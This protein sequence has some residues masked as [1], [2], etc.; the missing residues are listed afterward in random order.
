MPWRLVWLLVS[1]ALAFAPGMVDAT[2]ALSPPA[3]DA[4]ALAPEAADPDPLGAPRLD[5]IGADAI[6]R[7]VVAALAQDR[8]GFVWVATGDGLTRFDGHR[9]RPLER[10]GDDP[11]ARNLGWIRALLGGRDGRLWIGTETDGLASYDPATDRV[12]DHGG[13]AG[14]RPWPTIRAL[15]EDADGAIWAGSV[16][17]G[18]LR[19]DRARGRF[20][21][22][23]ADGKAG[24]LPDDRIFALQFDAAGTLWIG[25]WRGLARLA[26]GAR[27]FE[28]V[29]PAASAP[30]AEGAAVQALAVAGDGALWAGTAQ[31][32]VLRV[33]RGDGG[34]ARSVAPARAAADAVAAI[35]PDAEGRIWIGRASGIDL[36]DAGSG[37]LRR[38]L[39]HDPADPG[40]LAGNEVSSLLR[41]RDG[42]VWIGGYGLGLQRADPRQRAL[43][44]R[45]AARRADGL[46]ANP[47][48]RSLLAL[49]QGGLWAALHDGQLVALDAALRVVGPAPAGAAGDRVE[50]M[51]EA[52]DGT[53][54]IGRAGAVHAVDGAG[55][56]RMRLAHAGGTTQRLLP[57]RDGRLWVG[58]QEGL[59]LLD[60]GARSL[61]RLAAAGGGALQG[62]IFAIAEAPDGSVWIG[63]A[64]GLWRVAAGG[65]APVAVDSPAGA[66][67]LA[68]PIVLGLLFDR[69]GELWLDTAVAGLHRMRSFDGRRARFDRVSARHGVVSRPFGVNLIEDARGRIWSHMHVY[70][71]AR[72]H[73]HELTAADGATL[74]TGWFRSHAKL[75]DGRMV[76][77]GSRGLLVVEPERFDPPQDVPPVVVTELRIDGVAVGAGVPAQGIVL[78]HDQRSV[79]VEFAALDYAD[80]RRTRF[81]YRLDGVDADWIATGADYRVAAY[82]RLAP[83]RYLLHVRGSNRAGLWSPHELAIPLRVQPAWWQTAAARAGAAAAAAALLALALALLVRRRT[84]TLQRQREALMREVADRTAELSAMAEMLRL[85]SA[86]LEQASLTDPLTGLRNRRYL[87]QQLPADAAIAQRRW[88]GRDAAAGAAPAQADLLFFVVDIDHFKAVNDRHGH[89]A[90][91]AVLRQ[92]RA[93]LQRVFR[94][95]DHLVRWGGEEFLAVAR[96]SER[97]HAGE[98]AERL[99]AAVADEP[100]VLDDGRPL[101]CSVSIGFAAFPLAT[102]LPA[103]LDWEETVGLADAVLLAVKR[104]ARGNWAGL[105]QASAATSGALLALLRRPAEDWAATPGLAFQ[106]SR[107]LAP[108]G[109]TPA[110]AADSAAASTQVPP[111]ASPH[112]RPDAPLD[113]PLDVPPDVAPDAPPHAPPD[114]PLKPPDAA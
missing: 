67:G 29:W 76:F 8:A 59:Y 72:D 58:T 44:M 38:R 73:L 9:F 56:E 85:Q 94:D 97:A 89:A 7:G 42:A 104:S 82:G 27:T 87:A 86:E 1:C 49:P 92:M 36:H 109:G 5:R 30:A 13:A 25:H 110:P 80:P 34:I 113:V 98:L 51:A 26:R 20:D 101:A 77:G 99:R 17:G 70:D 102:S 57:A 79:G 61:R 83:G 106:G 12:V 112:T 88:S 47:D 45:R 62:D 75:A 54:W 22:W 40:A 53:R 18:L 35:V 4:D 95:S 10:D 6:P 15:A 96:G 50:A 19:F 81:A 31:G 111:H 52:A 16:G 71:P 84:R 33:G 43:R 41:D 14:A 107:P 32:E 93:R 39:R 105:V 74:G 66:E 91:D 55:R 11:A 100:F 46:F 37:A 68:N 90:G 60:R 114:T 78:R 3:D 48:A 28:P 103:A 24:A 69:R 64:H 65:D 108:A 2:A 21:S 23:R 63:N